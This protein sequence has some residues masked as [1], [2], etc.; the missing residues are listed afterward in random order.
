MFWAARF[1]AFKCRFV[2]RVRVG[3]VIGWAMCWTVVPSLLWLGVLVVAVN[4]G[5]SAG[6]GG[7]IWCVLGVVVGVGFGFGCG[8]WFD[9]A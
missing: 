6:L 7:W 5:W 9:V 4:L 1:A 3:Y 2:A 8:L